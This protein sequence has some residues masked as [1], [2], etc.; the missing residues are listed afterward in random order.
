M[1]KPQVMEMEILTDSL[2]LVFLSLSRQLKGIVC[3]ALPA[4]AP[5]S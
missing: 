5:Q 3:V 4:L 2:H 1:E